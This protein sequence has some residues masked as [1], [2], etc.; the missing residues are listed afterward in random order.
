MK[1]LMKPIEMIA[2]FTTDKKPIPLR[3]RIMDE[4]NTFKVIKVDRILFA[5]EEK[6]AGNRMILYRCE[7]KINNLNRVYELKYEVDSCKWFLYKF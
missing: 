3:Y 4:N 1:I 2:W 7:S 6:L 5:E